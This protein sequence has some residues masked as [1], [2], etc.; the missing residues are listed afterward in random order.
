MIK[1]NRLLKE[2][3]A[4]LNQEYHLIPYTN[5]SRLFSMVRR[6]KAEKEMDIPIHLRSGF[7]ISVKTGKAA[8]KMNEQEWEGFYRKLSEQL[9]RDY[10]RLYA[11]VFPKQKHGDDFMTKKQL[12]RQTCRDDKPAKALRKKETSEK[13]LSENLRNAVAEIV[14]Q[15]FGQLLNAS[16]L[17]MAIDGWKSKTSMNFEYVFAWKSSFDPSA[18]KINWKR[19]QLHTLRGVVKSSV[20]AQKI[21]SGSPMMKD[22]QKAYRL[23]IA[24]RK[25]GYQSA[26]EC[27]TSGTNCMW[28]DLSFI[29]DSNGRSVYILE[30]ADAISSEDDDVNSIID[31]HEEIWQWKDQP[32]TI[33]GPFASSHEAQ[34][35]MAKNGAFREA[36]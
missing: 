33:V 8:D 16:E 35:W 4:R 25:H 21:L 23:E 31:R 36:D 20:R 10:P 6:M 26:Q 9:R 28:A 30:M 2:K 7:A 12:P 3:L 22:E 32:L 24:R 5:S 14:H 34:E 1:D 19:L 15:G 27:L 13:D 11:S 29:T 18:L 17:R